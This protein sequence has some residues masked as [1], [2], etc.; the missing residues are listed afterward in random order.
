MKYYN[1]N[2]NDEDNNPTNIRDNKN[3]YVQKLK[4]HKSMLKLQ[5][6]IMFGDN[7]LQYGEILDIS[8][9]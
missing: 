7:N 1:K 3:I 5:Y 6:I 9:N 2:K 4:G 8:K